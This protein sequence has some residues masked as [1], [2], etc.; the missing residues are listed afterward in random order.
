MTREPVSDVFVPCLLWRCIQCGLML[1][2]LILRN[3]QAMKEAGVEMAKFLSDESKLRW[4]ESMRRTKAANKQRGSVGQ[5]SIPEVRRGKWQTIDAM[6]A[7]DLTLEQLAR[8]Q[9]TLE[10]AKEILSR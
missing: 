6:A 1:D 5:E 8:C 2:W 4:L 9:V 3:R 7:I 10:R